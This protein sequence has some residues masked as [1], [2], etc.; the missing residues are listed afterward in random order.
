MSLR[1]LF[2]ALALCLLPP[3]AQSDTV[4]KVVGKSSYSDTPPKLRLHNVQKFNPRTGR[5][6]AVI[7]Q[8]PK[9][10]EKTLPLADEAGEDGIL[11]PL[12]ASDTALTVEASAPPP[13]ETVSPAEQQRRDA[14]RQAQ[15][16]LQQAAA[17]QENAAAYEEAVVQHCIAAP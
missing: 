10:P 15:D 6:S 13:P 3:A 7:R 16:A 4:W 11:P 5:L 9:L 12:A 17:R 14:C 1:P 8:K 2:A